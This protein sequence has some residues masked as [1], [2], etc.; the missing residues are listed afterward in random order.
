[1]RETASPKRVAVTGASGFIGTALVASL[2]SAGVEVA[3]VVRGAPAAGEIGWD[4]DHGTIEAG[5]LEGIDAVVHLAGE[6]IFGVW[7]AAKKQRILESRAIGTRLLGETIAKLDRPPAV[8]VSASGVGY[9]GDA[10]DVTLT[11][12]SSPGTDFL[13]GVCLAW[14]DGTR[15]ASA[16]GVRVVRTRFGLVLHPAGGSLRLMRHAFRWGVGARLG[17][18]AQWMS[19][20]ALGDVVRALEFAIADRSLEGAVNACSPNPLTNAEFTRALAESVGRRAFLAVPAPLLRTFTLGM[21]E[22]LLLVSQRAVP[23][24]LETCGFEF[25]QPRIEQ[26]LVANG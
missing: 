16:A 9:Y 25:R 14:E 17:D 26:A 5:K 11:E 3:R 21:A 20:I 12:S 22:S 8:L 24:A 10:G 2:R 7:T 19:W 23:A 15:P 6:S 4:P 13:S 1:M 18:G